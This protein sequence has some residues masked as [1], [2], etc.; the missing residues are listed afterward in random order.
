MLWVTHTTAHFADEK[1]SMEED[2][3]ESIDVTTVKARIGTGY[4]NSF[5]IDYLD[6]VGVS[7]MGFP[8]AVTEHFG[9]DKEMIAR[10]DMVQDVAAGSSL[11][12]DPQSWAP[13]FD[14]TTSIGSTLFFKE[15]RLHASSNRPSNPS[16]R[17]RTTKDWIHICSRGPRNCFGSGCRH[18][19]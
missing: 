18:H 19:Q 3:N 8:W 4:K 11:P 1:T 10:V 14:A 5:S 6:G 15:P 2:G 12:W 17:H 16:Q 7:V 9:N 13:M